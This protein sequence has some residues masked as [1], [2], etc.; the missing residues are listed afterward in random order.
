V[1]VLPTVSAASLSSSFKAAG[2]LT[3]FAAAPS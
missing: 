2:S 3:A 1:L